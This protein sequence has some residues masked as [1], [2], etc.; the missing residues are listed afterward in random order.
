MWCSAADSHL[1]LLDRAVACATFHMGGALECNLLHRRSVAVLCMIDMIWSNPL[2]PLLAELPR[3]FVP[4]RV[5]RPANA[6]I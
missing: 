2:H 3:Q 5:T 1:S 4:V 6:G